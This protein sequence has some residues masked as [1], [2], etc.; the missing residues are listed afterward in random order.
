MKDLIEYVKYTTALGV[1]LL[2]FLPENFIPASSI[3]ET[4]ALQG[5]VIALAVS[6]LAGVMLYSRATTLLTKGGSHSGDRWLKIWGTLHLALLAAGFI[7]G[8][9]AFIW[10]RV[11]AP[12]PS[13]KC[14]IEAPLTGGGKAQIQASCDA[15]TMR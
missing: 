11:L 2:L 10:H 14:V 13:T 15:E 12:G 8:G 7:V 4:R 3:W 6:S 9:I 1:A 5:A